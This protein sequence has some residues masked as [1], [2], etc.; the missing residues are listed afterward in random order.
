MQLLT[1]S[2]H[3]MATD[4]LLK[5]NDILICSI[6]CEQRQLKDL[7]QTTLNAADQDPAANNLK[8]STVLL[9]QTA[10][11]CNKRCL[12]AYHHHHLERL[13]DLYWSVGDALP[14]L[15]S[16]PSASASQNVNASGNGSSGPPCFPH[17]TNYNAPTSGDC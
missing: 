11:L 3:S 14:L 5:Y 2:H 13:K 16:M 6:L 15:L 10:I 12:L 8:M 9:Y 1:E 7:L 4:T 17:F